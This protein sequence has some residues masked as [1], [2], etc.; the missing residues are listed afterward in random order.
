[1]KR[2]PINY[3]AEIDKKY[4]QLTILEIRGSIVTNGRKFKMVRCRC[5]CGAFVE[6]FHQDLRQGKTT[7]CGDKTKHP[8][9]ADRTIPAFNQL[10]NHTYKGRC[11]S[12]R[13]LEFDIEREDFKRLTSSNCHYCGAPPSAKMKSTAGA[14]YVYNGLD[15]LDNDV[16]YIMSNVVPCCSICNH[17]KHTLGY[18]QFTEWILRAAAHLTV[19]SSAGAPLPPALASHA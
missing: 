14:E 13:N 6:K 10:Y 2:S 18:Q 16:G 4:G 15:R 19:S 17:A 12:E 8:K 9:Y 7:T 3:L 1:M 11:S 5:D